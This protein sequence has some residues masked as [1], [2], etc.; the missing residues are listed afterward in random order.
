[1]EQD[2]RQLLEAVK[3]CLQRLPFSRCKRSVIYYLGFCALFEIL[4][5]VFNVDIYTII[6]KTVWPWVVGTLTVLTELFKFVSGRVRE[7]KL[8]DPPKKGKKTTTGP[9]SNARTGTS[10]G[11]KQHRGSS[12]SRQ[13]ESMKTRSWRFLVSAL[14]SLMKSG[15]GSLLMVILIWIVTPSC[16]AHYFK[17]YSHLIVYTIS[18]CE[19][20]IL[21]QPKEISTVDT[22]DP[23]SSNEVEGPQNNDVLVSSESLTGFLQD[24]DALWELTGEDYDRVYFQTQ[25]YLVT[26]WT[27]QDEVN[28]TVAQLVKELRAVEAPNLFDT[29]AP[30]ELKNK[31]SQANTTYDQMSHA[32]Q[33]DDTIDIHLQAWEYPKYDIAKLLSYEY[34]KYALEYYAADGPFDTIEYYYAQSILWAHQA[35]TFASATDYQ[36]KERLYY[37]SY[38]YHDIADAAPDGSTTQIKAS[39]LYEAYNSVRNLEF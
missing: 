31:V 36:V 37:I 26:D 11:R 20:A 1:M 25:K 19:Q 22:S 39:M 18:K 12:H 2:G 4:I 38:R 15:L 6:V 32:S 14:S 28:Q 10:S 13:S 35:I 29:Q 16:I 8:N 34:Q 5:L 9:V 7:K 27:N 21:E 3:A 33:L 24:P 23:I 30:E 17:P